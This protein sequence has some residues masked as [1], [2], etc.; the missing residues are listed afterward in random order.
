MLSGSTKITI[1]SNHQG[2]SIVGGAGAEKN[3]ANTDAK[4]HRMLSL[5]L[6]ANPKDNKATITF[7][8]KT[9]VSAT[10]AEEDLNRSNALERMEEPTDEKLPNFQVLFESAPDPQ[11]ILMSDLGFT[12]VAVN[13]AYLKATMTQREQILNKSLFEVFP[14]NPSGSNAEGAANLRYSLQQVVEK[15]VSNTM[16]IQKYDIHCPAIQGDVFEERYSRSINAPVFGKTGTVDFIIHRVEDVTHFIHLKQQQTEQ[17]MRAEAL[18]TRTTQMEAEL[19]NHSQVIQKK[20]EA[21]KINHTGYGTLAFL[22]PVGIFHTDLEGHCLYINPYWQTLTGIPWEEAEN[23]QWIK[24]LQP[25]DE[26]PVLDAWQHC[27]TSGSCQIEFCFEGANRKECWVLAQ[28]MAERVDNE[29]KGYVGSLTNITEL[30]ELEKTRIAAIQQTEEHQRKLAEAAEKNRRN[31]EQFIDTICHELRNPLHGIYGNIELLQSSTG[32]LEEMVREASPSELKITLR[33]KMLHQLKDNQESIAAIDKCA[34]Y[35]KAIAD[36]VLNLSKLEAGKV[37]LHLID[38]ELIELVRDAVGMLET[39]ASQK[40]IRLNI[41]LPPSPLRVKG[42]PNRLT[43]VLLN[44]LSNALKFTLEKGEVIIGLSIV[45]KMRTH[46]VFEFTVKDTGIGM[47]KAEKNKLFNRFSQ[48]SPKISAEHGGS[49]LGLVISKNLIEL[50]EGKIEVKSKK[51]KGT[52]FS[53]T[54]KFAPAVSL[55]E[56]QRPALVSFINSRKLHPPIDRPLRILIAEDNPINQKILVKQLQQ[57]GH[58][59]HVAHNGQEALEIYNQIPLD[60]ILMD[61][62]MP[63]KNGFEAA[64]AIRQKE[65]VSLCLPT[66]IIGLSGNVRLEHEEEALRIGMDAYLTKPYDKKKLLEMI[67]RYAPFALPQAA[68]THLT[69]TST[70]FFGSTS[71]YSERESS[72]STVFLLD[73]QEEQE[74]ALENVRIKKKKNPKEKEVAPFWNTRKLALAIAT[75]GAIKIGTLIA[76][77]SDKAKCGLMLTSRPAAT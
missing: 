69:S 24:L 74:M 43:Q 42:D 26:A 64:Q 53:F 25:A 62:E 20:E 12:I 36:D 59:C 14:D 1:S 48:A 9:R 33:E 22:L 15:G 11:L 47:N 72:S 31:Q 8:I 56:E 49:G 65:Q 57:A 40:Q 32:A 38:F 5:P 61:I 76:A 6:T 46:T 27:Q 17:Q 75:A 19:G 2:L 35:Q 63:V 58:S 77:K 54:L 50:M 41:N 55:E 3:A 51:W 73:A 70:T 34:R 45:E 30:K 13:E 7:E 23:Q 28:L 37:E 68:V 67:A 10:L 18:Q 21:L 52:E 4:S 44:L 71:L 60:L 29:I 66:P 39:Q 16:V